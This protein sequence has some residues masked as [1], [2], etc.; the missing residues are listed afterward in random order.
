MPPPESYLCYECS[1]TTRY[2]PHRG[3]DSE[4]SEA[5]RDSEAS[6]AHQYSEASEARHRAM[7]VARY[8]VMSRGVTVCKTVYQLQ[9]CRYHSKK[10]A[11][12]KLAAKLQTCSC[13]GS[14]RCK[15]SL[16]ALLFPAGTNEVFSANIAFL[17]MRIKTTASVLVYKA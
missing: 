16:L 2:R 10:L 14:R 15:Q 4:A 8:S 9:N 11:D 12:G 3:R 17:R 1:A 6:E 5:R 7:A 13:P